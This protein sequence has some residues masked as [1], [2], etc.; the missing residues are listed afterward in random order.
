MLQVL[1]ILALVLAR[2]PDVIGADVTWTPVL[3]EY[4][5]IPIPVTLLLLA[6]FHLVATRV[7]R[8]F[9]RRDTAAR[10]DFMYRALDFARF[11]SLLVLAFGVF[12][13]GWDAWLR[14][15]LGPVILV[16]ELLIA[17]PVLLT[18]VATWWSTAPVERA[19]LEV[20]LIRKLDD[21]AAI[22]PLPTRMQAVWQ[23]VRF[24][25]LLTLVPIG[26]MIGWH[27]L[28]QLLPAWLGESASWLTHNESWLSWIGIA[29]ILL[30]TPVVMRAVWDTVPLASSEQRDRIVAICKLHRVRV[31]GPLV[32]RTHGSMV[33]GA[34]LGMFWPCRYLLLTDALLE[35]MQPAHLDA[36]VAHEVAHVRNRHMVW[37]GVVVAAAAVCSGLAF[38]LLLRVL[39]SEYSLPWLP[40]IATSAAFGLAL[41][42]FIF[43]SQRFEWQADAFSV[44]HLARQAGCKV[45]DASS[46]STVAATLGEVAYANGMSIDKLSIRHGSIATRQRKVSQLVGVSIDAFPIDRQVRV[47]K[48][49]SIIFLAI[50][51]AAMFVP[52]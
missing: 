50:G 21:G 47:I 20:S 1:I 4:A 7:Y 33:N 52:W 25:M 27:D 41:A 12:V 24:T 45:V 8:Q 29:S 43:A 19:M 18:I 39:P 3:R 2:L 5:W 30:T 37:L 14:A 11:T 10:I 49:I 16:D 22:A 48:L 40:V 15:A 38:D 23:H 6:A 28:M 42:G 32:W 9:G 44:S 31:I 46:A 26:L 51:I 17:S 34:I 35:R 13:C 36:I